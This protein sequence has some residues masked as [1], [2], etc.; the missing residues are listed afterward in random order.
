VPASTSPRILVV[1]GFHT[2]LMAEHLRQAGYSFVVLCPFV[3]EGD[4]DPLYEKRMR[5]TANVLAENLKTDTH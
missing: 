4:H 1:G 3:E 5:E 2:A